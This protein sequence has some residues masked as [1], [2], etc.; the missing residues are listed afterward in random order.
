MSFGED[1][2]VS[3]G[4]SSPPRMAAEAEE[5]TSTDPVMAVVVAKLLFSTTAA[6]EQVVSGKVC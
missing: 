3:V 6:S 1:E 4:V 5:V 2:V